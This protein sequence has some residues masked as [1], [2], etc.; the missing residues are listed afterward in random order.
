MKIVAKSPDHLLL[1]TKSLTRIVISI[2]SEHLKA[3]KAFTTLN[4]GLI[5]FGH[6]I[7]MPFEGTI[8]YYSII[9]KFDEILN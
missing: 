4:I 1:R 6:L 9:D 2:Q 5:R 8:N 3:I 7:N